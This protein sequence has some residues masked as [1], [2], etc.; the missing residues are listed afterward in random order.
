MRVLVDADACPKDALECM[1]RLQPRYGYELLTFSNVHHELGA[2]LSG[3][4]GAGRH[5][6]VD[7]SPQ[8]VDLALTNAARRGDLIVTQDWGLAAVVLGRGCAA[9]SP[10]GR[11]YRPDR[12]EF[13]LEER[14]AKAKFRRGG[15]RTRGPKA[16][17]PEDAGRFA[18][19]FEQLVQRLRQPGQPGAAPDT[20]SVDEP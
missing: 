1:I 5:T 11:E 18:A 2:K 16:R 12:I 19:E 20:S 6:T 3:R 4:I 8:A 13:M 17:S 9:L 10:G 15:G 7:G 14:E